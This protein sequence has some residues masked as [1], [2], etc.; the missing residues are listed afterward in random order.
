[1]R[2]AGFVIFLVWL[3]FFSK[4]YWQQ[5]TDFRISVELDDRLHML[6]GFEELTYINASPDTLRFLMLHLWPNA[7]KHDRTVFAKEQVRNRKTDF[8]FSDKNQRGFI[9]SLHFVADGQIVDWSYTDG[10]EDIA[11]LELNRPLA[12]GDSVIIA[13]PFRVK[14]PDLFSRLGHKGQSYFISQWYPKPAVYD[15]NGWHPMH[16]LD[17]GEFYSEYG[18]F[19]VAVTLPCDYIVMGAGNIAD[20]AERQWLDS[21]ATSPVVPE[22]EIF[23]QR[24]ASLK[25]TK[26]IHFHEE[27]IHDFSWFADKRW[28]VRKEVYRGDAATDSVSVYAAFLPAH[29]KAWDKATSMAVFALEQYGSRI[30]PYPYRTLKVVEGDL[31]AGGGMEYPTLALIDASSVNDLPQVIAHEV[32]HNWFYGMLGSDERSHPWMDESLNTYYE[33]LCEQEW[34][35]QLGLSARQDFDDVSLF[36]QQSRLEDQPIG[37]PS[38][39]FSA[40]NYVG[41]IYIKAPFFLADLANGVGAS[42]VDS[43]LK[44]YFREYRFRHPQPA[45]FSACLDR[46]LGRRFPVT[47]W[48]HSVLLS[49]TA[50]RLRVRSVSHLGD[51]L[52]VNVQNRSATDAPGLLQIATEDSIQLHP[53][54]LDAGKDNVIVLP[55]YAYQKWKSV[56]LNNFSDFNLRDNYLRRGAPRWF[57]RGPAIGPGFGIQR[58]EQLKIFVAPFPSYNVYDGPAVGIGLHNLSF[59]LSRFQ[60]AVGIQA[61][62][63]SKHLNGVAGMAYSWYSA[64]SWYRE[65]R[66]QADVKTFSFDESGLNIPHPLFSRYVKVAPSFEIRFKSPVPHIQSQLLLKQYNIV[67]Q[68]FLFTQSPVD[69]LYR[70]S[71]TSVTQ[72]YILGRLIRNSQQTFHPGG[73]AV[74]V[75]VGPRFMKLGLDAY[76]RIDYDVK[77]KSL[78]LRLFAGKFVNLNTNPADSRYWLNSTFTGL[79]D[80]LYDGLYIRRSEQEGFAARQLSV[81]EGG[82][83]LPTLL[84]ASPLG[85]SR[86]WLLAL[87]LS[88]DLPLG[89]LPLRAYL[90]IQ[91]LP[92]SARSG[93]YKSAFSFQGGAELHLFKDLVKIYI[94]VLLSSDYSEYL[95]SI[96]GKDRLLK[97]ITWSVQIRYANWMRLHEKL[98][99]Q[100]V[101]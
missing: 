82:A 28:V 3:P 81:Q 44:I 17:Q 83:K 34:R 2:R 62:F 84:Y 6:N 74:Q 70:P 41:D 13:T 33:R 51:S 77:G 38:D 9:D 61:G 60:F 90:D 23:S 36:F 96:Y 32:G 95:K 26:T 4:A 42:S 35:R 76:K 57:R 15:Q 100:L 45:D 94:P 56:R 86:D 68:P 31:E 54:W 24:A 37:I 101:Q 22:R 39:S 67:E 65:L 18:T 72:H 73:F 7:Y 91:A 25:P 78:Y 87:N 48:W 1:M 89:K 59:P 29:A 20:A 52:Y 50:L 93:E 85:R 27:Q 92:A 63:Q 21:L 71:L 99:E 49:Q 8:Y 30:G 5:R 11:R 14:I 88:S 58:G 97:S 16:Y 43:V 12:P 98:F 64:H 75:E 69:S 19:D 55:F 66:V 53:V 10:S 80:Y 46:I 47:E 79:N 40:V